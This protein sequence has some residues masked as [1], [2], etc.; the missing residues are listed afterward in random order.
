MKRYESLTILESSCLQEGIYSM[1]LDARAIAQEAEPGQFVCLYTDDQS[2]LL[3]RPISICDVDREAGTVRLV[4]RTVG[5]GT[6]EFSGKKA[7]DAIT[8]LGPIGTGYSKVSEGKEAPRRILVGGGIGIP[9][10]LLLAKEWKQAG[11]EVIAVLGYRTKE[12]F[13]L[14]DMKQYATCYVATDDGSLGTHGTVIDAIRE[15]GL[16]PEGAEAETVI[17]ACGPMPMLRGLAGLAAE[18]NVSAYVSLEERMACGVG[19]CLGC[20][21][22]TKSVDAHSH[23]HNARICT[24]GPVFDVRE[25]CF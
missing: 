11:Y 20:I 10:M 23:V 1:T 8:V 12:T 4:Y 25:L 18:R 19:A 14:D 22:K 3:P 17:A 13:L 2:R 15:N 16:I 6:K 9:P 5:F 24:E 7:G 21:T